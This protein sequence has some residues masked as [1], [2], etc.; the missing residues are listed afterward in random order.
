MSMWIQRKI[1]I[2]L[3][4]KDFINAGCEGSSPMLHICFQ[5]LQSKPK[6]IQLKNYGY[7]DFTKN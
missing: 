3:R 5:M 7:S 4:G 6:D 1:C 2:L